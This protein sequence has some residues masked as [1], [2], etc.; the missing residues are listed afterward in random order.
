MQKYRKIRKL[1]ATAFRRLTG[2]RPETFQEMVTI[3]RDTEA[4]RMSKG[5]KAHRLK[6][7]DR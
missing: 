2:V 6:L 7:E 1:E 3:L 4:K 5:G